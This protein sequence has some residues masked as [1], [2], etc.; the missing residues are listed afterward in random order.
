MTSTLTQ[1]Y[2]GAVPEPMI[3]HPAIEALLAHR[4]VRAFKPDKLPEGTLEAIIAAA[5]SAATS[6]NL[7][8]WSVAAVEDQARKQRFA[9]LAG[10]QQHIAD[11]PLF[12]VF[13]ADHAR[14]AEIA[15][16]RAIAH[17]GLD[18]LESYLVAA[19]DAALA[20]QNAAV[21]AEALGLG[22]V[23]IGALRNRPEEVAAEL[24]LP[25]GV[26][27]VF[28]LCIGYE[29]MAGKTAIKPRL[30]QAAV[31][32]RETYDP[33][34]WRQAI[35]AYEAAM[36]AFNTRERTGQE[37]WSFRSARRIEAGSSLSGRDRLSQALRALGFGVK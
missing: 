19:I 6:S 1:R 21:A 24:R 8:T 17:G 16:W 2:G 11:C 32:H 26:M 18:Y 22:T 29:D 4:S 36:R 10:G 27:A 28:G 35:E 5:Q 33:D 13:L 7:Q 30:P 15:A 37:D 31:L 23:Y 14:L 25:P 12:L 20:A 9:A 34:A 3:S